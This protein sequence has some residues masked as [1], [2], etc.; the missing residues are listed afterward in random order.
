MA[1]LVKDFLR[2]NI[3]EKPSIVYCRQ[4][5]EAEDGLLKG[6]LSWKPE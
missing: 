4:K 2:I 3:K 1:D 6:L 5:S